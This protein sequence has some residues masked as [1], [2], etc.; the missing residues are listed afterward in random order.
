[1]CISN[2]SLK[3]IQITNNVL[4]SLQ[5]L[6]LLGNEL[7]E[8]S[9]LSHMKKLRWC[10]LRLNKLEKLP[11]FN[12]TLKSISFQDNLLTDFPD[13]LP[14]DSLTE[15]LANRN[16]FTSIPLHIVQKQSENLHLGYTVPD[17]IIP[18]L[19]LGS[20]EGASFKKFLDE[21]NITH[22]VR[23]KNSGEI[24]FP[25]DYQYKII[26]IGDVS[27]ENIEIHFDSAFEFIDNALNNNNCVLVHCAMGVSRSASIVIS[28]LMIFSKNFI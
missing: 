18:G 10:S 12:K 15:I 8:L 22:I 24:A 17:M 28:Y 23:V 13:N 21:K 16:L 9:S 25:N 3:E 4:H 7:V 5:F 2:N 19:Y 14:L 1:M 6:D 11:E 26:P 20:E 27:S